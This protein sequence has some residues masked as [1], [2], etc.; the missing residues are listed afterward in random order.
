[1]MAQSSNSMMKAHRKLTDGLAIVD[2]LESF[3]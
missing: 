3:N 2:Q 1:M